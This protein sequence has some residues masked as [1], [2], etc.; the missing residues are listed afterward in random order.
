MTLSRTFLTLTCRFVIADETHAGNGTE[1]DL[2]CLPF[3]ICEPCPEDA[4]RFRNINLDVSLVNGYHSFTS[5]S[6]VLS[7]TGV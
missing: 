5:H 4:V 6:V 2:I 3:G 7:E 1:P